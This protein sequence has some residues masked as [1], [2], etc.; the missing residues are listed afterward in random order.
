MQGTQFSVDE[1]EPQRCRQ[2]VSEPVN[3]LAFL[4]QM[5]LLTA[6]SLRSLSG[7]N[8]SLICRAPSRVSLKDRFEVV[9]HTVRY[10]LG[11]LSGPRASCPFASVF[12]S[13]DYTF[14]IKH[15]HSN[16]GPCLPGRADGDIQFVSLA[17]RIFSG[18]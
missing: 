14:Q 7:P 5:C 3:S 8:M 15:Q 17:S 9:A 16:S 18:A 13:R 11:L 4:L 10:H 2:E 1:T 12:P 6:V